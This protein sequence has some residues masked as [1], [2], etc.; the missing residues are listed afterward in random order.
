MTGRPAYA[1]QV[2]AASLAE[3]GDPV[4]LRRSDG[5]L[6]ERPVAVTGHRDL[7]GPYPL[8]S[9]VD[10][11]SLPADLEDIDDAVSL[12]VVADPLT[13]PDPERLREAF[14]D[15]LVQ[16][17][18]H[19][20]RDLEAPARLPAHHRRHLRRAAGAV[21]VEVLA[22]PLLFLDDWVELYGRLVDRHGLVGIRAFSRES[23]RRQLST[24]GMFAV[25]AERGGR[26]VSMALWLADD[27]HAYYHLGASAP[28]GYE[29]S[30]SYAV[31]ALA[32]QHAQEQGIGLVDLGGVAGAGAA[33]DGLSRFKGGWANG[34]RP[35]YLC[36]RILDPGAYARLS[37][38][39]EAR[40]TWFPAYRASDA[41]LTGQLTTKG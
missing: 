4:H 14:P 39:K 29:V 34:D 32:L 33:E 25:R 31:F 16:F 30:A 8:F 28:A 15:R 36:G 9:C 7:M 11:A 13:S 40:T 22:D 10:W 17:K 1:D 41:D 2:Y 5:W 38:D 37:A 21:E 18:R 27:R 6:L 19:L 12:V 23:F 20:T 26:T 24:P 3:F 35:A